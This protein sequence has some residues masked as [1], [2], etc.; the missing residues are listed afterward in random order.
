[1]PLIRTCKTNEYQWGIW[2]IEESEEELISLLS[3]S[4]ET[5]DQALSYATPVR[6]KEFLAVRSLLYK[7]KGELPEIS[8]NEF[9]KPFLKDESYISISHTKATYAAVI[10]SSNERCG[11]DIEMKHDR[12]RKVASR[13]ISPEEQLFLSADQAVEL[14]Q[15]LIIWSAKETLFKSIDAP[16]IDFLKQMLTSAFIPEPGIHSFGVTE[17]KSIPAWRGTMNYLLDEDFVMTWM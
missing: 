7:L 16:E 3:F 11:I 17:Y 9:G 2:K 14:E 1:M 15:L 10:L 8:Y 12:V 13:F 5:I 6:R 4:K